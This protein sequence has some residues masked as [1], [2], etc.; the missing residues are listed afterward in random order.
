MSDVWFIQNKLKRYQLTGVW[1]L[2]NKGGFGLPPINWSSKANSKVGERVT[3]FQ[4]TPRQVFLS[5]YRLSELH[6]EEWRKHKMELI[7]MLSPLYSDPAYLILHRHEGGIRQL[8]VR[9]ETGAEFALG[10][11]TR[12]NAYDVR[13]DVSL[14]AHEPFFY[15]PTDIELVFTPSAGGDLKFP[16]EFDKQFSGAGLTVTSSVIEYNDAALWRTYPKIEITGAYSTCIIRNNGTNKQI[17]M[18]GSVAS[19]EKRIITLGANFRS[20]EDE[21]G[22]NKFGELDP[23]SEI[24]DFY[25]EPNVA[26]QS[27]TA[28]FTGITEGVTTVKVTYNKVYQGI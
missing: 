20:I 19:G 18:T 28:S 25:I 13:A 21:N 3:G 8:D 11:A 4:I 27:I 22:L 1:D 7:D 16:L 15:D 23:T 5:I 17:K 12:Q 9:Y 10:E 14:I 2:L 26:N 6:V 24:L